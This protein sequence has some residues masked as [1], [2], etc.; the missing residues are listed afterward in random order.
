MS[1]IKTKFMTTENTNVDK[2]RYQIDVNSGLS[3]AINKDNQEV[4]VQRRL[5]LGWT[6]YGK[7]KCVF[8]I[9]Q[10]NTS[11]MTVFFQQQVP[12]TGAKHG[13]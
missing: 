11:S 7:M 8:K 9:L 4:E 1:V 6:T 13:P 12:R 10:L 5:R 2:S 3:N